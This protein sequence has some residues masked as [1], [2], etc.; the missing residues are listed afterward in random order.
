M[1]PAAVVLH[2]GHLVA[3]ANDTNELSNI[4]KRLGAI[5][6]GP[7][8]TSPMVLDHHEQAMSVA[9]SRGLGTTPQEIVQSLRHPGLPQLAQQ[10]RT[11]LRVGGQH[12]HPDVRLAHD[13][14]GAPLISNPLVALRAGYRPPRGRSWWAGPTL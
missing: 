3:H 4:V 2:I 8:L 13:T 14:Q 7:S 10:I 9:H 1:A 11:S 12:A 6:L 5:A